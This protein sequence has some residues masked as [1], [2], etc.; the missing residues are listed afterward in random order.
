MARIVVAERAQV[1]LRSMIRTHSL[2]ASTRERVRAA[3]APLAEFPQL[4][5]QLEGRWGRYRVILGPWPWMLIVYQW[6][7]VS[8]TVAL[9]TMQDSR[10]AAA[11]TSEP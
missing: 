6:D 8:D 2:P 5:A 7:E 3:I 9:V 1:N 10:S 11:P 4:G